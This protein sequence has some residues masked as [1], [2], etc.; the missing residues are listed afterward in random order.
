MAAGTKLPAAKLYRELEANDSRL[1]QRE[2]TLLR[3]TGRP[4]R[5][6]VLSP[7]AVSHFLKAE[8]PRLIQLPPLASRLALLSGL[9]SGASPLLLFID[10]S[11]RDRFIALDSLRN[12][13]SLMP[14]SLVFFSIF[15]LFELLLVLDEGFTVV[16][17]L[18]A[19][20]M[21]MGAARRMTSECRLGIPYLT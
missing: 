9:K 7:T 11:V 21:S 12:K 4:S 10:L 2:Q 5:A 19:V 8:G 1:E 18:A 20:P 15:L 14:L 13:G 17:E 16:T 3:F 6:K